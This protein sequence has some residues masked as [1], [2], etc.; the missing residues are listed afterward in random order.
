M[1]P[2]GAAGACVCLWGYGPPERPAFLPHTLRPDQRA[3]QMHLMIGGVRAC[4]CARRPAQ[5]R[6][7]G[8]GRTLANDALLTYC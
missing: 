4:V 5:V 6:A 7:R 8:G 3:M 2:A 1:R